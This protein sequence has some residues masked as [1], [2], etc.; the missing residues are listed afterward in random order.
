MK[1]AGTHFYIHGWRQVLLRMRCPCKKHD[2]MTPVK[3]W[4]FQFSAQQAHGFYYKRRGENINNPELF[5]D[6]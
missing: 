6:M 3:V 5:F 1:F 4:M 2:A